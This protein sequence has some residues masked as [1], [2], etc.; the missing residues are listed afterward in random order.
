MSYNV[1][2]TTTFTIKNANPFVIH[3][4]STFNGIKNNEKSI[5]YFPIQKIMYFINTNKICYFK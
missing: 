1:N 3:I 2:R 5:N 4:N